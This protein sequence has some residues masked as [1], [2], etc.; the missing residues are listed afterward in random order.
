MS[1]HSWFGQWVGDRELRFTSTARGES[2]SAHT[3][4]DGRRR[5]RPK[6]GRRR[7]ECSVESL[8][9]RQY[10]S[11]NDGN[12]GALLLWQGS[13]PAAQLP[14][15]LPAAAAALQSAS[16]GLLVA[17][18]GPAIAPPPG[19]IS[20]SGGLSQSG[21]NG[22]S[23]IDGGLLGTGTLTAP[24]GGGSSSNTSP[25]RAA[26]GLGYESVFEN[27]ADEVGGSLGQ[28]IGTNVGTGG[29]KMSLTAMSSVDERLAGG[30]IGM[31]IGAGIGAVLG[32][33]AGAAG[34]TLALPGGGTIALGGW[35]AMEGAA[36]GG[37]IGG[38]F[39]VYLGDLARYATRVRPGSSL[40]SSSKPN[41]VRVEERP[42]GGT[43]RDYGADGSA[44]TDYD[45]GHDHT[46]AGDPHAHDWIDGRRGD[47]RP[48]KPGE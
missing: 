41:D 40:P 5:L 1:L 13:A 38:M 33:A 36:I 46:G 45:F 8:E 3:I 23:I 44:K 14:S 31:T 21:P 7:D 43:I 47:P 22:Q 6:G 17:T 24:T 35:G 10:L 29:V 12:S 34:G 16:N 18:I 15:A 11:V 30:G 32:G 37:A 28:Q 19:L 26:V 20:S 39:G 25:L 48:L 42:D 4:G 9:P 2:R 27:P